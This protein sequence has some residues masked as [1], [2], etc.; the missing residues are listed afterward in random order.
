MQLG[1]TGLICT[2][3]KARVF[4]STSTRLLSGTRQHHLHHQSNRANVVINPVTTCYYE[5]AATRTASQP[6][7][8]KHS[9]CST[10]RLCKAFAGIH[11]RAA[12][13]LISEKYL[14]SPRCP[15]LCHG[16][17]HDYMS[18][19]HDCVAQAAE[20]RGKRVS[21][22]APVPDYFGK[23]CRLSRWLLQP[24]GS[25]SRV[26]PPHGKLQT[27]MRA[28]ARSTPDITSSCQGLARALLTGCAYNSHFSG[29]HHLAHLACA[30]LLRGGG[31]G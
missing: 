7:C 30:L 27:G 17:T 21:G 9:C 28:G 5:V 15:W 3:A 12:S 19:V 23:A 1:H 8:L 2:S 22:T 4:F 16:V 24:V 20:N 18:M 29:K 14:S 31:Q 6:C 11:E 25:L 13:N 10:Q 26:P